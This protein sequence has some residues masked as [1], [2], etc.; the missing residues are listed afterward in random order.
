M[1]L[2]TAALFQGLQATLVELA[3][4]LLLAIGLVRIILHDWR[5]LKRSSRRRKQRDHDG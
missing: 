1:L 5:T 3:A 2:D 4:L